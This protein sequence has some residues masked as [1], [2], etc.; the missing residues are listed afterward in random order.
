MSMDLILKADEQP[1]VTAPVDFG[2]SDLRPKVYNVETDDPCDRAAQLTSQKILAAENSRRRNAQYKSIA[3][4]ALRYDHIELKALA[5]SSPIY[6]EKRKRDL[7]PK[8]VTVKRESSASFDL[9]AELDY[10]DL[11]ISISI[12]LGYTRELEYHE[13]RL[14]RLMKVTDR[15]ELTGE[16]TFEDLKNA[17]S[18]P[19]DYAFCQ[20]FNEKN[21]TIDAIA[22]K[23]FPS[24]MFFV[25]DTFF[26]DE[27]SP[28]ESALLIQK[29]AERQKSVREFHILPMTTKFVFVSVSRRSIRLEI[30]RLGSLQARLGQPYVYI[31][32]GVCEHLV[33]F[34]DI[35]LRDES[36]DDVVFPR[37]LIERNFRRI[38]CDCCREESA[39]WMIL[40]H[41]NLMPNS[42]GYMCTLCYEEMCFDVNGD[43]VCNFKAVPYC[44]RKEIGDGGKF[45]EELRFN[46]SSNGGN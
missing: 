10:S 19:A 43:K 32:Q 28:N 45:I 1:F 40:E 38:A 31:H 13:I 20:D 4:R 39:K 34:N 46:N 44:D 41:E 3:L 36:H 15:I 25:H 29:W 22:K 42:P 21:P 14:G 26:V 6:T 16:N 35:S 17:F 8:R 12:Y 27:N 11:I 2:V 9:L 30:F 7:R 18:C 5:R 33:V 37:R 24:S 23:K